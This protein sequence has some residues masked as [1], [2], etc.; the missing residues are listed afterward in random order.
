MR[1]PGAGDLELALLV[2]R[3]VMPDRRYLKLLHGNFLGLPDRPQARFLR[4]LRRDADKISDDHIGVL[5]SSEWR[6][7]LTASWLITT[8]ERAQFVDPIG[9]LLVASDRVYAGQGFSIALASIGGNAAAA[10][11]S[12]YLKTWLPQTDCRFDQHWAMAALV[13]LDARSQTDHASP[14]LGPVGAWERWSRDPDELTEQVEY[15]QRL[16]TAIHM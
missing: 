6:S 3:Y 15:V 13:C 16:L 5:L 9:D 14:F 8:S 4:R 7:R 12:E 10:R 2:K 11:L 1:L